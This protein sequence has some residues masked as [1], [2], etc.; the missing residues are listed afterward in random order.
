MNRAGAVSPI[1]G[2][3]GSKEFSTDVRVPDL[4]P[5]AIMPLIASRLAFPAVAADWDL[6]EYLH[7]DLKEAYINPSTLRVDD[8]PALPKGKICGR[9][10]EFTKFAQRADRADGLEIFGDDELE[11]DADGDGDV[12]V[13]GFFSLWKSATRDRTITARLAH[14]MLER[15]VG[16]S[17]ELLAHGVLLGEIQ[18]RD[19]EK[20]R[21]SGKDLPDAY[22]HGRVSILR[23]KTYAV[24][25][26]VA[27]DRFARG[28]AFVRMVARRQAEGRVPVIPAKV[29]VGWR[30]LAMGDLNA[31]CFMTTAHGNLLRRHGAARDLVR[32]R[33]PLP[34]VPF[35]GRYHRR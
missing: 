9:I 29:R 11:R 25:A 1:S 31:V 13:A 34:R 3:H 26:A 32:Y 35:F 24:G 5:C 21:M 22:H 7:G 20:A 8:P 18:L 4:Q 16:V 28:P 17:G 6:A 2:L 33:A 23:A 12:I 19:N 14:N 27:S 10:S 15:R 30:S